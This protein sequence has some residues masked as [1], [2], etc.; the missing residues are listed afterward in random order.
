MTPD[1]EC[2]DGGIWIHFIINSSLSSVTIRQRLLVSNFEML[3]EKE[4]QVVEFLV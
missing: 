2:R 3:S 1:T 4:K